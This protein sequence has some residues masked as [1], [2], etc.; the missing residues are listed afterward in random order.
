M[1]GKHRLLLLALMLC[2]FASFAEAAGRHYYSSWSYYPRRSY[3]YVYYYYKP[4]P[5]YNS[6]N[7]HYCIYYPTRPR[8]V[9]Y[10][11]PYSR[12]YWGRYDLEKKG[13]SMLA[14]KD[15]KEKLTDIAE[16]AF[17]EPAE[18]PAIPEAKDGERMTPPPAVP[19]NPKDLPES[20]KGEGSNKEDKEKNP[21]PN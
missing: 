1:I 8:Y 11:N 16:S 2:S 20:D 7:Y 21:L 6:Y 4:T 9:Y 10:Y 13:Y 18:M 5:T 3:Y 14:D 12:R 19:E 15:R 17:P